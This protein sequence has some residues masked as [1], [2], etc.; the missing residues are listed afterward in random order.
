MPLNSHF[1]T[2]RAIDGDRGI[3]NEVSFRFISG[4]CLSS[5]AINEHTGE[6]TVTGPVDRDSGDIMEHGGV[7]EIAILVSEIEEHT[8]Q[9]GGTAATTTLSIFVTDENDNQPYFNEE[10]YS[11]YIADTAQLNYPVQF[12]NDT[13]IYIEDK[14]QGSS[15]ILEL[16]LRSQDGD[17]TYDFEP[18]PSVIASRGRPLIALKSPGLLNKRKEII[19]KLY[20]IER[21]TPQKNTAVATISIRV[22]PV[23]TTTAS[24]T[25]VRITTPKYLD[26]FIPSVLGAVIAVILLIWAGSITCYIVLKYNGL[27]RKNK[28][29]HHDNPVGKTNV[30]IQNGEST[31]ID[32]ARRNDVSHA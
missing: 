19:L 10:H 17:I 29:G 7:C 15:G 9:F 14:D 11:A 18:I 16:V 3:P 8:P 21:D 12:E 26:P 22:L 4:P 5:I 25:T 30:H 20:A 2:V 31:G 1:F 6:V 28:V 24:A 13:E 27:P 32:T 23:A